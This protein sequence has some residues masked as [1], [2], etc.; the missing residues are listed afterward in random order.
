MNKLIAVVSSIGLLTAGLSAQIDFSS[1]LVESTSPG[2]FSN[3]IVSMASDGASLQQAGQPNYTQLSFEYN[4]GG[5]GFA[6]APGKFTQGGTPTGGFDVTLEFKKIANFPAFNVQGGTSFDIGFVAFEAAAQNNMG[7]AEW[8]G[9]AD[10]TNVFTYKSGN[11]DSPPLAYSFS[12]GPDDA[13]FSFFAEVLYN[14]VPV[15]PHYQG[16]SNYW[17]IFQQVN[18]EAGDPALFILALEDQGIARGSDYDFDDGFFVMSGFITPVP[19]PAVIGLA[20]IM[21]LFGFIAYRR[22]RLTSK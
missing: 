6:D 8:P 5:S 14:S 21:A 17:T 13:A 22:R 11:P 3:L 7:I 20:G 9:Y 2:S 15:G 12:N 1:P 4:V 10:S 16:D 19:E 18:V